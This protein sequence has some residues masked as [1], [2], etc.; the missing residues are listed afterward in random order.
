MHRFIRFF[1]FTLII[2]GFISCS[3]T[4]NPAPDPGSLGGSPGSC[5]SVAFAGTYAKGI[6]LTAS[7]TVT[8]QVNVGT[9]AAYTISTNT[10]NGVSF[11]KS[12]TFTT[13]GLQ[14]VVLTG[15]GTPA[16]SGAQNFTVTFG[17]STCTFTLNF[18]V[19]FL[20]TLNGASEVPA[21]ASTA[22]GSCVATFNTTTKILTA[23]TIHNIA[24]PTNGHFH[25]GAVGVSGPVVLGFATFISPINYVSPAL[26]ATQEADLMANLYYDNIHTAAF[27]GGEIRGQ[28]TK[29]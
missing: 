1:T 17:A 11:T 27:P 15:S 26:D 5:T 10:V 25:K 18:D 8:V 23:V 7:N 13:T 6:A 20:A 21:N 29:Q 2:T 28:L 24:A 9:A 16:A 22:T 12:G 3:K 19:T 4:S 14:S